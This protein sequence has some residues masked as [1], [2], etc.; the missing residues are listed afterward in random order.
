MESVLKN[1]PESAIPSCVRHFRVTTGEGT[2]IAEV[3]EHHQTR[4]RLDLL[5]PLLTNAVVVEILETWGGLPAVY[6]IR[7]Y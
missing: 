5:E 2:V 7:C 3:S 1:H 6:E 4:W